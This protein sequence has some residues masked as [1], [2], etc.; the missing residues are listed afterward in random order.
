MATSRQL[1]RSESIKLSPIFSHFDSSIEGATSIR[2]YRKEAHFLD[3]TLALIDE[4]Q[5][6]Y[7]LSIIAGRSVEKSQLIASLP[8]LHWKKAGVVLS[9][10]GG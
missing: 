8:T 5:N 2:A 9:C 3:R 6:V 4:H 1:K 7:Y 10:S